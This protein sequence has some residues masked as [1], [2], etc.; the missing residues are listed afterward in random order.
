MEE[1]KFVNNKDENR[2]ELHVGKYVALVEYIINNENVVYLTHTEVPSDLGGQG[3]ASDLI[4][5]T[6]EDIKANGYKVYPL[7]PFV[8]A[9]IRKNPEWASLVR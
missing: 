9:Y 6:L 1:R 7:C 3:V 8:I 2:Y 5:R 4:K